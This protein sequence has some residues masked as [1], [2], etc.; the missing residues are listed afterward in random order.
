MDGDYGLGAMASIIPVV[1]TGGVLMKFTEHMFPQGR[2]GPRRPRVSKL[3]TRKPRETKR[4]SLGI[5]GGNFKNI[6]F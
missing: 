6:G 2:Y 3:V 1:V 4:P 5:V